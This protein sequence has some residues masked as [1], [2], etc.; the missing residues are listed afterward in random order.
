MSPGDHSQVLREY[1]IATSPWPLLPPLLLQPSA[2][3]ATWIALCH[4][5]RDLCRCPL[6]LDCFSRPIPANSGVIL[7]PLR[8]SDAV[9]WVNVLPRLS[10]WFPSPGSLTLPGELH[11]SHPTGK[12]P[13]SCV[14]LQVPVPLVSLLC[15]RL[16]GLG[17]VYTETMTNI[18]CVGG[19]VDKWGHMP[20]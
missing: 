2:T 4:P 7:L 5:P 16:Q 10:V 19:C 18:E 6:Y 9:F 20:W 15:S 12:E 14:S 17:W 8:H 11:S 1:F 13:A 3:L